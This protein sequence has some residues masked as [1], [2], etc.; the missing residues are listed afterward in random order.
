[1]AKAP[2]NPRFEAMLELERRGT[3]TPE[4]QSQ[5]EIARQQGVVKAPPAMAKVDA[6]AAAQA[7]AADLLEAQLNDVEAQ[8]NTNL[9]GTPLERGFGVSEYLPTAANRTFDTAAGGLVAPAKGLMRSPG[10]GSFSDADLKMLQSQIPESGAYD[11]VNEQRIKNIR[12]IIETM[13]QPLAAPKAALG[14][15]QQPKAAL[16]GGNKAKPR[17]VEIEYDKTGKMVRR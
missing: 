7:R 9:K 6:T 5:L 13:R 8:Y 12:L 14:G 1:M 4:L 11:E 3:I 2:Y 16:G 15:A 17:D 10:E